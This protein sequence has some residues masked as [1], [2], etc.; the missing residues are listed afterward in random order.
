MLR[1]IILL[2]AAVTATPLLATVITRVKAW[3]GGRQG[4]PW[5]INYA[6]AWKL[7]KKT[8]V[9]STSTTA[10]FRMGPVITLAGM[11]VALLL[12]PIAGQR[13]VIAFQG[14]VVLLFYLLGLGRFFTIAAALDTA[15]PFEGMGAAREAFFG[16]LAH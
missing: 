14:D 13:P 7:L 10:V 11:V 16:A 9:Y 12:L 15:S 1:S 2:L 3:F 8:P 5:L 4:P 6:T